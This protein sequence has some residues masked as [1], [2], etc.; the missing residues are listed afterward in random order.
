MVINTKQWE[1]VGLRDGGHLVWL[2]VPRTHLI[3]LFHFGDVSRGDVG[4]ILYGKT[5]FRCQHLGSSITVELHI[6]TS[7][8]YICRI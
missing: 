1:S 3:G 2:L 7:L 6:L 8:R 5:N 4:H